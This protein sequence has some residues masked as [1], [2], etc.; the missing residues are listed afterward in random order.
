MNQI[1]CIHTT[2]GLEFDYVGVI[3]G[4]DMRFEDGVIVTDLVKRSS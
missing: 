4:P 1:D 3:I 2:Q